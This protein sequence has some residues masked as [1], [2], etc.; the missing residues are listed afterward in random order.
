MDYSKTIETLASLMTK[1]PAN[2][3]IA[4]AHDDLVAASST[5]AELRTKVERL[6]KADAEA[7]SFMWLQ[8]ALGPDWDG[9][10][11][12]ETII[13]EGIRAIE[14]EVERLKALEHALWHALDD[15]EEIQDGERRFVIDWANFEK[16]HTMLPE[17]H[18]TAQ[19]RAS[20]EWQPMETAPMDV[21]VLL[22]GDECTFIGYWDGSAWV[23]RDSDCHDVD[24]DE[25]LN[26]WWPL[27]DYSTAKSQDG[28]R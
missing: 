16:L 23:C 3:Q 9:D 12:P 1:A 28:E 19:L 22:A 26:G 2:S 7:T 5:I 6:K 4:A 14:A 25:D 20:Q 17:Q 15:G 11:T 10:G 18:P 21:G 27:P 13:L 8:D 24:S